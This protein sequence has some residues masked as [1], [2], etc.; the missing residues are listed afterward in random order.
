MR[1]GLIQRFLQWQLVAALS[2]NH[3]SRVAALIPALGYLLLYNDQIASALEFNFL[4][5]TENGENSTFI[6]KSL[7]KLR[8]SFVGSCC[9]LLANIGTLIWCPSLV[10]LARSDTEFADK[11]LESYSLSEIQEMEKKVISNGWRL[12]TPDHLHEDNFLAAKSKEKFLIQGFRFKREFMNWPN[13]RGGTSEYMRSISREWWAGQ[14]HAA[15]L[16]RYASFGLAFVGFSML[17]LPTLDIF[18]AVL[19]NWL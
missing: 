4:A 2:N 10:K 14:M 8:L 6:L 3:I 9:L 13:M 7:D 1:L 16:A 18:Q 5:G 11:V 15:P 17:A 12:R 19:R